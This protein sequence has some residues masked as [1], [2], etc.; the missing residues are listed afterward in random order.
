MQIQCIFSKMFLRCWRKGRVQI[1]GEFL[2][3]FLFQRKTA[4]VAK[5]WSASAIL[6][7]EKERPQIG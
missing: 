1:G 7:N 2:P 5:G 4:F 3:S 6:E